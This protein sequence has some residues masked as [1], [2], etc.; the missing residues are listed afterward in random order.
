MMTSPQHPGRYPSLGAP[1]RQPT[2]ESAYSAGAVDDDGRLVLLTSSGA[3]AHVSPEAVT[4]SLRYMLAR[5]RLGDS[6]ELPE[7][8]GLISAVSGEGVT[9][10]VRSLGLVLATDAARR[11]CLVDL[12]WWSPSPWP[13]DADSVPGIADVLRGTVSLERA[14][15]D[16][17]NPNLSILPAGVLTPTER[18]A[19]A[20]S[21]ELE[22]VLVALSER[23]DH[24]LLDLPAVNLTSEALTL[25]DNSRAVAVVVNQGVTPEA[26]IKV[27]LEQ[28]SGVVVL[29]VILNRSSTK[30]P[31]LIRRRFSGV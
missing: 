11:V 16:T 9:Y 2:A 10:V 26:Q 19:L 28:L 25:A 21:E 24:V 15:M 4:E 20:Q 30:V 12:N 1:G 23:F 7:R 13:G 17:G 6:G 14:L 5:L 22:K 3:V 27:A 29:G 31:R 18:P 8:L